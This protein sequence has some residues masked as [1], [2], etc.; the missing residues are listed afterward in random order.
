MLKSFLISRAS[1]ARTVAIPDP[2]PEPEPEPQI[3]D[4]W[5]PATV[6]EPGD[7]SALSEGSYNWQNPAAQGLR[8]S[9]HHSGALYSI[10][11]DG[12]RDLFSS[13]LLPAFRTSQAQ[14]STTTAQ[15]LPGIG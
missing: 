8:F 2:E 1:T 12:D 4:V 3:V 5:D 9:F 11:N 7:Y 13:T 10:I 15:K 6:T 14:A